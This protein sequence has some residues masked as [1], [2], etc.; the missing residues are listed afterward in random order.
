M[1]RLS[2][3]APV[4]LVV[5]V[6]TAA[7]HRKH[8]T[9]VAVAPMPEP[10]ADSLA[11]A[12]AA[13][14]S[15]A[16]MEQM[17]RDSLARAQGAGDST[18][19]L[20]ERAERALADVRNTMATKIFFDFDRSEL[21]DAAKGALDAKVTLLNATPAVKL[22]VSGNTDERGSDEYNMALGQ[23]R[24]A[25]AKRYL[26]QHGIDASR[27]E[28]VSFGKERPAASGHDEASWAQNRRDEFEVTAGADA[29]SA[30]R[31]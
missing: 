26:T 2:R 28:T 16:R 4:F 18:R 6:M 5:A 10:N 27:V 11:R 30:P 15:M 17:R 19:M 3:L 12:R 7:C 25:A 8:Q 14:D 23:R 22:R 9:Q 13:S 24:A 21:T 20:R 1:N 31:Q 29:M